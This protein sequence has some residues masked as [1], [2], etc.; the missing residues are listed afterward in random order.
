M[1]LL[2]LIFAIISKRHNFWRNCI[3]LAIIGGLLSVGVSVYTVVTRLQAANVAV[4]VR[5]WSK[6][7][8]PLGIDFVAGFLQV[9]IAFGIVWLCK[10]SFVWRKEK[11]VGD[12]RI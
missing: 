1:G 5:I 11:T 12:S 10:R 9:V 6:L 3:I 8:L 7:A 4:D 2:F